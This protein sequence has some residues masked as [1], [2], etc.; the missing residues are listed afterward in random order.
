MTFTCPS[1]AL[2]L[3]SPACRQF[4]FPTLMEKYF[5]THFESPTS[6]MTGSSATTNML[7]APGLL[8]T[9]VDFLLLRGVSFTWTYLDAKSFLKRYIRTTRAMQDPDSFGSSEYL[10]NSLQSLNISVVLTNL[11]DFS[12]RERR[13]RW[14][15]QVHMGY[16]ELFT[17][18]KKKAVISPLLA[19]LQLGQPAIL[20]KPTEVGRLISITIYSRS[21]QCFNECNIPAMQAKETAAPVR[22]YKREFCLALS[23][24]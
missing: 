12:K 20:W 1:T 18:Q 14:S 19:S 23:G 21:S 11:R 4:L 15:L 3:W 16:I 13:G 22:T 6:S 7:E 8:V 9:M 17:E 24:L 2:W 5:S 10:K